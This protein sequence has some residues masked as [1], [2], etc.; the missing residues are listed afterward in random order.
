MMSQTDPF[1][2]ELSK[3][4]SKE[5]I[6]LFIGHGLSAIAGLPDWM[7][8][9]RP[10]AQ[11]VR[12]QLPTEDKLITTDHLLT[13][14]QHYENQRSRQ[15]LIQHLRDALESTLV[16]TATA[17]K[18]ISTLPVNV[19]FTTNYDNLIERALDEANRR[20]NIIVSE[21][22][23][24]FWDE[25][26]VQLIKLCGDLNRPESI[27]ITKRDFNTYC[28]TRSRL[29][30]RLRTTLESKTALFIGYS[31][32]DPFFNQIWD[33]IGLD[34]GNLRRR[35]YAVLFD[36][37]PMET[38][39]LRQRGIHVINLEV[40][41]HDHNILLTNWLNTLI[42]MPDLSMPSSISQHSSV[43][44]QEKEINYKSELNQSPS[45]P[46]TEPYLHFSVPFKLQLTQ[47]TDKQFHVRAVE[48]LNMGEPH[49]TSH[50]PYTADEL[51]VVLKALRSY[52]YDAN[53]FKP[54]QRGILKRLGLLTNSHFV[55][56]LHRCVGQALYNAIM[57]GDVNI[58]FQ[59]ALNEART[60]S[61]TVALQLRFDEDVTLLAQYPWELLYYR[62][63]LLPSRVI[64]LTRYITYPE[65]V[66][67]LSITPPLRLLYIKSRPS[68]LPLADENEQ[69]T[70]RQALKE[71]EDK[72]IVKLDILLQPSYDALLDYL[73][74]QTMHILHFD[75]HGVFARQCPECGAMNYSHFTHCQ[76]KQDKTICGQEIINVKP[77]GYLAFEDTAINVEWISSETIGNLLYNRPV[78]IAVLSACRSGGVGGETLFEGTAPAL[79][80][81]GLPA[82]ISMQLPIS[83]DAAN[84]F[85][86]GFYRAL[87]RFEPISA[88]VNAG[89]I[90]IIDT[91]EWFIPTLYLRSIDDKGYLFTQFKG[92]KFNGYSVA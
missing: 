56:D 26:R 12:Y 64:E 14:A 57:P 78:G 4:L 39:D 69:V 17:H 50:L 13:A 79:I 48:T 16:K 47:G 81:A 76:K 75:G 80:Q 72:N 83:V 67:T 61:G 91:R 65:A 58:A 11:S 29:A 63:A 19:I 8:L 45:P 34:F 22:D 30:E 6:I 23:L 37:N 20:P 27:I 53:C 86:K 89:R 66:T 43:S 35:S 70:I 68:N 36:A 9:I 15:S 54:A 31:L 73:E 62:R 18:I 85:A 1:L 2:T 32:Q 51:L 10:L 60:T 74:T 3:L 88:A 87:A 5:D 40:K 21:L 33:H 38:D 42:K 59:K 71:L 52:K 44:M 55:P 82:V 7:T 41:G 90:R 25:G 49:A 92:G 77:M 84:K 28:T 24:S 46:V